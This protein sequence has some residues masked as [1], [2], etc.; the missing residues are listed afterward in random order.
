[1]KITYVSDYLTQHIRPVC[2]ALYN[3]LG[4][5][6]CFI[7]EKTPDSEPD[8]KTFERGFAYYAAGRD[9]S[10]KPCWYHD[11]AEADFCRKRII[12]SDAVIIGNA[13]DEMIKAR[14]R[15]GKLTMRANEPWYRNKKLN[16]LNY[17]RAVAGGYIHHGRYKNLYMLC[18]GAYT[19]Y[20]ANRVGCFKDKCYKW[21]YFPQFKKYDAEA[22]TAAKE[23]ESILWAGRDISCKHPETAVLAAEYLE[24]CGVDFTLYMAGPD[25]NSDTARLVEE[26]RLSHRVKLLGVVSPDELRSYMEKAAVFL[27]TSDK[28]EGWGT[29]LN[30]ALNSACA[31]IASSDCGSTPFLTE[32][33]KNAVWYSPHSPE[34]MFPKLKMLLDDEKLRASFGTAAYRTIENEWNEN[35]A[36]KRLVKLIDTLMRGDDTAAKELFADGPCSKASKYRRE[37]D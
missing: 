6:F 17:P 1:M 9:T 14:L 31:V 25:E 8:T 28:K 13:S 35:I 37:R 30:E 27:L 26:K 24:N 36:A 19:A 5:D 33:M 12:E 2:E 10:A 22:L 32:D 3:T 16:V 29:V 21:G 4:V 18:A 7:A 20:D 34:E 15:A 23:K 11:S